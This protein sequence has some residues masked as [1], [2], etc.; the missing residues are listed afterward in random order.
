MK[1]LTIAS[2]ILLCF[3]QT[4]GAYFVSILI[5]E[6]VHVLM[7]DR[8]TKI[9]IAFGDNPC[10]FCVE[11]FGEKGPLYYEAWAWVI[12]IIFLLFAIF[13]IIPFWGKIF[14]DKINIGLK[15]KFRQSS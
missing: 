12:Q 6:I 10:L 5:H 2:L 11:G 4:M 8:V 1:K 9:Y 7:L 14:R 3:L 15:K 13:L